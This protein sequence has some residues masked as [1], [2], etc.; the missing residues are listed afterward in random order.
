MN[1]D[2]IG[3]IG[4]IIGSIAVVLTLAFLVIQIRHGSRSIDLQNRQAESDA[5]SRSVEESGQ[6]HR[7]LANDKDLAILWLKGCRA[8]ELDEADLFRFRQLALSSFETISAIY[9]QNLNSDRSDAA[10]Q[11]VT[12]QAL[13]IRNHPGLRAFWEQ[14]TNLFDPAKTGVSEKIRMKLKEL[15]ESGT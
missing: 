14:N 13:N 6:L 7:L 8:D 2:A 1:W 5:V 4:E 10:E 9:L 12:N 3:A 11:A 15:D